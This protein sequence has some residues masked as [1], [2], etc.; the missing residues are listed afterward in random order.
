LISP[1]QVL[2]YHKA[3]LKCV[4]KVPPLT[5]RRLRGVN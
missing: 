5:K 1:L 4:Y 3:Y 2:M